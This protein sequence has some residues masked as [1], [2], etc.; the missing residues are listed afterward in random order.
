MRWPGR[1]LMAMGLSR[2]R[3]N[4]LWIFIEVNS[5][6]WHNNLNN[7]LTLNN[8]IC[9]WS[10][11]F[12]DFSILIFFVDNHILFFTLYV[13]I[14]FLCQLAAIAWAFCDFAI[15]VQAKFYMFSMRPAIDLAIA[16]AIFSHIESADRLISW[17]KLI[18]EL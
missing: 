5:S 10:S 7:F 15:S 14:F 6:R 4:T 11:F 2:L 17:L 16:F 13:S 12:K 8:P 1:G 9:L 3:W 18:L